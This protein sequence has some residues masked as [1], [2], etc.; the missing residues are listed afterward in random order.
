MMD[1]GIGSDDTIASEEIGRAFVVG[2]AAA[3]LEDDEGASHVVPLADV[4][5]GVG[6]ET[7]CGDVTEGHSGGA[8]HAN[9]A[10]IAVEM[11]DETGDNGLVGIAVVGQLQ[12]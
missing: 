12:T 11:G 4:T 9:A 8:N 6:V 7:T 2:D 10:D 1:D 3:G 5:L